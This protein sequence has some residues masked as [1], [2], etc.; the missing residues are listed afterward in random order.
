MMRSD[1]RGTGTTAGLTLV[2]VLVAISVLSIGILALAQL[3]TVALQNTARAEAINRTTRLGRG[4]LEWQRQTALEPGSDL[5]SALVPEDFTGCSVDI[6]P[7]VLVFEEDGSGRLVCN[8]AVA[9]S[10][11]RVTV[12]ADGPRGE[13]FSLSTLWTG[14]WISGGTGSVIAGE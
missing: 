2:E 12:T 6:V 11:Y 5:C 8:P 13:T 10:T 7:C 3:Q 14:I 9:P 4:E 1:R